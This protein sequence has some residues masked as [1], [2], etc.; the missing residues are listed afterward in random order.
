MSEQKRC[1]YVETING[2]HYVCGQPIWDAELCDAHQEKVDAALADLIVCLSLH[3][4]KDH[5]VSRL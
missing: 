2:N 4:Y 5:P 1:P 3:E